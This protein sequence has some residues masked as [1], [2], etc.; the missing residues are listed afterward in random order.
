MRSPFLQETV[1]KLETGQHLLSRIGGVS[2]R[3][4]FTTARMKLK[5]STGPIRIYYEGRELSRYLGG[6]FHCIAK[7]TIPRVELILR[8][9]YQFFEVTRLRGLGSFVSDAPYGL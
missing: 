1:H 3:T 8:G 5:R 6:K 4:D 7:S 2:A 9:V